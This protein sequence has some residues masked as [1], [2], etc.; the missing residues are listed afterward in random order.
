MILLLTFAFLSGLVTILA[1]CIWPILPII[2][3]TS[4]TGKGH[5]RPLGITLGVM[6]SFAFFTLF[7][8]T[9]V[10][11]FHIDPNI[12]RNIAVFVIAVLGIS[13]IFPQFSSILEILISRLSS[14]LGQNT[15]M[16]NT[17]RQD[18]GT[19][20]VTGLSLGIVWS[21]CAGPIL[22]SIAALSATGQVTI[23]VVLVT[24]FYVLG[25][26][27]PLFIFSFAGQTLFNKTRFLSSQL[28]RIQQVFGV[29]MILLALAIYTHYDTYLQAQLL[30]AFPGFSNSLNS[31]ESN[32]QVKKQLDILKGN[33]PTSTPVSNTSGLFNEDS[34]APDFVGITKWLNTDKPLSISDLKGKVV[35]VDFWTYTC[36]NCIRTLPHVTSWYDKYK[37]QGFVVIGV[38]TP[39]F[40]FEHETSNVENA[41][42]MYNIHYP[43]AQD[44]NYSTW[45]N[46]SNQYW[47]AEYL[48]DKDGNIRRTH[49]GE[50]EYDQMEMTIQALLKE[51][52]KKVNT[53]LDN[54]PDTT[55]NTNISPETYVGA[56]RMEFYFPTGTT[57]VTN[58][59][60]D[61]GNPTVNSFSLGGNWN[62]QDEDA[63]SGSGAVLVYHF[64]AG[65]VFL[66]L[67]PP[68]SGS[69]QV[70]VLLDGKT[71][72]ATNAGDDATNGVV[73]V[74][75]DR[76][77]SLIN[78]Q[79]KVG[80]H[81]LR[82]EF[83]TPGT[84]A[85]AFTFGA[86]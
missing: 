15:Q 62:I 20:L 3:S 28:G 70:K 54:M 18:F 7:I 77:Y 17:Q 69:G 46:Y 74:D 65:K 30:N 64:Y 2:L 47:P 81:V 25:V 27:I 12:L 29:L 41:I 72:G 75:T 23:Y 80:D 8:S 10:R 32:P 52:G 33:M 63:V 21:P 67:R 83:E 13:M 78:L 34:P 38:H 76:L 40:E 60:F 26:G 16:Q 56:N 49:F 84:S 79:G 31:F 51:A 19:G 50:G 42:K 4:I 55:P 45:N 53:T 39:E 44:N 85:F 11:L 36:I 14:I 24:F 5:Q 37:D 86:Q 59:N 9:L 48:I 66:V 6:I 58:K 73:N 22:A 71:V 35:L 1:P 68:T 82:L 61:L 43:V 57:G